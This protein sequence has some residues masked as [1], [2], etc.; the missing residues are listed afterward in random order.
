MARERTTT[1]YAILGLL[2]VRRWTTYELTKQVQRSLNWFWPRAERKLYDEPK[3]LVDEGLATASREYTGQRARTVYQITRRGRSALRQWLDEPSRPRSS[4]FE[5]MVKV[6]FADAGSKDQ[7]LATLD[8]IAQ[9]AAARLDSLA[10]MAATN[11]FPFPQ[12]LHISALGLQMQYEQERAMLRWARWATRQVDEWPAA[13]DPGA[14]DSR[15]VLAAIAK[16][17]AHP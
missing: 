15:R 6:F 2:S 8:G 12:R 11:P 3:R 9:E 1:T 16:G 13:D 14:W 10:D 7:L 17:T 5:A 4:E